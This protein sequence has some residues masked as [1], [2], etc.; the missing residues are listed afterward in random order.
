MMVAQQRQKRYYNASQ[1]DK[2]S[3]VGMKMLLSTANLKLIVLKT[4]TRKLFLSGLGLFLLPSV[5]A[6]WLTGYNCLLA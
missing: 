5:L 6:H 4:D 1:P 3:E 2:S